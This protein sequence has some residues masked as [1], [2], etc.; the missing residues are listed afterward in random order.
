MQ[1]SELPQSFRSS[2]RVVFSARMGILAFL[3]VLFFVSALLTIFLE[4]LLF[5]PVFYGSWSPWP[6]GLLPNNFLLVFIVIF[7]FNLTFASFLTVT[8]PGILFFPLSGVALMYKAVLWGLLL[9]PVSGN[10][11]LAT[12]PTLFLEGEA[13]VLSAGAGTVAGA[14]WLIHKRL[15]RG[16]MLSRREAF[17]RGMNECLRLYLLIGLLLLIAAFVETTTLMLLT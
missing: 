6:F 5:P 14:S 12:L 1:T 2:V 13:Y 11:L 4:R 3:N 8:L 17:K 10:M 16:E 9:Y 7:L 15:Y